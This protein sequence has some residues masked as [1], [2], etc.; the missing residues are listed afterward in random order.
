MSGR[1][2]GA[3]GPLASVLR[4]EGGLQ[5]LCT[6]CAVEHADADLLDRMSVPNRWGVMRYAL[7]SSVPPQWSCAQTFRKGGGLDC[8]PAYPGVCWHLWCSGHW[9]GRVGRSVSCLSPACYGVLRGRV[10]HRPREEHQGQ[11]A[12]GRLDSLHLQGDPEGKWGTAEAA[13]RGLVFPFPLARPRGFLCI[14]CDLYRL[15][16]SW[17]P[18]VLYHQ[19]A[20]IV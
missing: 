8:P 4:R 16:F 11:H 19:L 7:R 15:F 13:R 6:G 17:Q 14:S 3:S 1:W 18:R 12:Q 9:G 20:L 2:L 5:G 10:H